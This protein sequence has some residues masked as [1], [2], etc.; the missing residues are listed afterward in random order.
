LTVAPVPIKRIVRRLSGGSQAFLVEGQDQLFYVAKFAGNPQGTRTLINEWIAG[1]LLERLGISMPVFR[2]LTLDSST[3]QDEPLCFKVGKK[4][5]G[6]Q[7]RFHF[8]SQCPVDPTKTMIMDFIPRSLLPKVVNLSEFALMLVFDQ[9]LGQ[10]DK[11]QA[12]FL[13]EKDGNRQTLKIRSYFIDNGMC[14]GG[15]RWEFH[16]APRLGRYIDQM[17]YEV[18]E[19]RANC[20][21]AISLVTDL[22]EDSIFATAATL[23][24]D[25][26][27]E[28]DYA[29]LAHLLR[30][31]EQ[32]RQKLP[33]L[34][35]QTLHALAKD[36]ESAA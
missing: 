33:F 15:G 5:V 32:R 19:M 13:R 29:G 21:Y 35:E 8:G 9:W 7:G 31:L 1:Q 14:F 18:L 17:L 12:V 4:N 25:W 30:S 36:R 10:T 28:G 11:R 6:I 27:S 26:Y 22:T 23:P 2:L 24:A 20:N 3:K 34:V 16:D